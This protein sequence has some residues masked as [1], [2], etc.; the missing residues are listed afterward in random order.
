MSSVRDVPVPETTG[1]AGEL[2]ASADRALQRAALDPP[3]A[4][5]LALEVCG[6]ARVLADWSVVSVAERALGVA[7]MNLCEIDVRHSPSAGGGH[8]RAQGRLAVRAGEARMSLASALVLAGAADGGPGDR[9][10]VRGSTAIPAAAR[11][12]STRRSSRSSGRTTPRSGQLRRALPVLRRAGDGEW[13]AR[14]LSNRSLIHAD[15]RAFGAAETDL[16][17]ALSLCD[18]HGLDLPA[19][20]AEQNLGCVKARRG[21]VP[22]RC[23]TSTRPRS[24]TGGSAWSRPPCTSTAPRSCSRCGCSTRHVRP[25]RPPS[26]PSSS[27]GATSTYP[28]PSFCC[29]RSPCCRVTPPPRSAERR[30]RRARVPAARPA[31]WL[32]LARYAVIQ[33]QGAADPRSVGPAKAARVADALEQAGWKV[34]AL[35]ARILAGRIALEQGRR[36]DGSTTPCPRQPGALHRTRGRSSRAWLAEALLRRAD[37]HRPAALSALRAGLHIVE[38]HQATL[39][40]TELRAHVSVHRGAIARSGSADGPRGRRRAAG[41]LVGRA[42]SGHRALVRPVRPPEDPALARDLADLRATMAEIDEARSEGRPDESRVQRQVY[43]ERR[44]RDRCRALDGSGDRRDRSVG[45]AELLAPLHDTVLASYIEAEGEL[46]V[47]TVSGGRCRLHPLGPSAPV[48]R[49]L[50]DADAALR[51]LARP[52]TGSPDRGPQA[53]AV[54]RR[55][56]GVLDRSLVRPLERTVRDR[57]L[58]VVPTGSLQAVPWSVLPSCRGRP[59]AV[60]P[61][62]RTWHQA[63]SRP[64]PGADAPVVVV[65]GP[66]L[67]GAATEARALAGLYQESRLL[68]GAAATVAD[69]SAAMDGAAL[70][71][72]AAH[73]SVRSD[74]PLFSSVRLADGPFTVYELERLT[75]APHH[76]VLAACGTARQKVVAAEELLGFGTAL[77]AGGTA[78]LVAPLVPVADAATVDLM[79]AYHQ[80]LRAGR[81]PAVALATAQGALDPDNPAAVATG[82]AFVCVGAV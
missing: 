64:S 22:T 4:R 38:D 81:S 55:A 12:C 53:L 69:V 36:Y 17:E 33:A 49:A 82:A 15:R 46:Y 68:V 50:A 63:V 79:C 35:E 16:L 42:R 60:T 66:G 27:S 28:R 11:A 20:Y 7:A 48:R 19:A 13:A 43:L 58:V 47:V 76:V 40:A 1:A 29:P 70:L 73:G 56:A 52:R 21:D 78:T 62:V 31:Q 72:L 71:H 61:S 6:T 24:A 44:I 74:N 51:R 80:A 54:L 34:P 67:P 18:E 26:R 75:R 10:A 45:L 39:G 8:G 77:L 59:V 25:P 41:A 2:Q 9:A 32:A 5:A 3:S 37:G 14:A 57:P 65:A 30:R 23:G